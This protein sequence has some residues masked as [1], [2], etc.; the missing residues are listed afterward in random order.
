MQEK[1]SPRGHFFARRGKRGCIASVDK[2][3]SS[4]AHGEERP[5]KSAPDELRARGTVDRRAR[6]P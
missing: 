5:V 3:D 2:R 1:I 6:W 4:A